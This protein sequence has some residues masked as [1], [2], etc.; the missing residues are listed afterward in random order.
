M[1]KLYHG[2][3]IKIDKIDLSL[4]NKNKDFGKGFFLTS[5]QQQAEDMAARRVKFSKNGTPIV[6]EFMFDDSCLNNDNLNVKIFDKVSVEWAQF[7]LQNRK[8]SSTGFTHNY[9]IVIGPVANDGVVVQLNLF[10]QQFITI[11]EL[12]KRLEYRHLNNQY[13]FGT[14]R[15]LT[16]LKRI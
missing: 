10:E 16:Y 2:S 9:D 6:T 14:E 4:G 7:I 13:F 8:A 1:L 5:L 11:E 3:D 15:S 12:V